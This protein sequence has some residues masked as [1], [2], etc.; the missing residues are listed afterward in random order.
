MKKKL[1]TKSYNA[2]VP[3]ILTCRASLEA[4]TEILQ[5]QTHQ[6]RWSQG[7]KEQKRSVE[8]FS[9]TKNPNNITFNPSCVMPVETKWYSCTQNGNGDS[10]VLTKSRIQ[11]LN[12]VDVESDDR[13]IDPWEI[14]YGDLMS[15]FQEYGHAR[16]PQRFF[17]NTSL[18][19]W[20]KNLRKNYKRYLKSDLSFKM[21]S[22]WVQLLYKVGF[23]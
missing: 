9:N 20:V 5:H 19:Q 15:F 8:R 17:S 1:R 21:T 2:S 3:K 10:S 7:L 13:R 11:F 16:V 6:N 12:N 4:S 22:D 23:E 18:G 14:S